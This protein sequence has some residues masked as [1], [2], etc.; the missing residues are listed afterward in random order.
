MCVD[1]TR[2]KWFANICISKAKVVFHTV[3][4]NVLFLSVT[5]IH[6]SHVKILAKH[7][8]GTQIYS[9]LVLDYLRHTDCIQVI[10][11]LYYVSA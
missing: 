11:V 3:F 2:L 4:S 5:C 9:V 8:P 7:H 6:N 1:V 10:F